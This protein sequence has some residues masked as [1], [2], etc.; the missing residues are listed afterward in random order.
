MSNEY[1]QMM[2]E[3]DRKQKEASELKQRRNEEREP[4]RIETE[5]ERERKKAEQGKWKGRGKGRVS[6]SARIFHAKMSKKSNSTYQPPIKKLPYMLSMSS[7]VIQGR[8][9]FRLRE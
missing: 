4:K 3:N 8:E 5:H 9:Y 6:A 2:K 7:G 1:V